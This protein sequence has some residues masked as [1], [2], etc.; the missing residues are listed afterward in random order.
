MIKFIKNNNV[1][2]AISHGSR[3][4]LLATKFLN[5]PSVL[6]LDYE[7]TEHWI[8]NNFSTYLLIPSHIPDYQ[9]INAKFNLKKIIRYGGFKEELYLSDFEPVMKF[10]QSLNIDK[11]KTL[12]VIRPPGMVG[13]YHDSISEKLLLLV[14]DKILLD[15]NAYPLVISRTKEDYQLIYNKYRSNVRFLEKAVDGLQVIWNADIFISGGGTMNRESA[16]LG[17]PTYSIFTGKKPFLDKH[18]EKLGKLTFIDSKDKVKLLNLTKRKQIIS[19]PNFSN[20]LVN[21]ITDII[22]NLVR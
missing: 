1:D 5:I 13:N 3:T 8:F 6:M 11:N 18:L 12:I 21:E 7:Y 16:L 10:R 14:L 9:L 19:K 15:K 4:Q 22:C 2:L 17:I 20:N